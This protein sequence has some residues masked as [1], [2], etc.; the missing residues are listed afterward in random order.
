MTNSQGRNNDTVV[1]DPN[2]EIQFILDKCTENNVNNGSRENIIR[3][4]NLYYYELLNIDPNPENHY[5]NMVNILNLDLD[6]IQ[7][8]WT[9]QF[10]FLDSK[11]LVIH[12]PDS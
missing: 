3:V 7:K 11:G 10:E 8:I 1:I 9:Y 2:E 12:Y 4:I 5:D 6:L